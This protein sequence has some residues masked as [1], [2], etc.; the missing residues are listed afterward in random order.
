[1]SLKDAEGPARLANMSAMILYI[2]TNA[3]LF[4]FPW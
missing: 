3:V 1:M 2:I 4:S